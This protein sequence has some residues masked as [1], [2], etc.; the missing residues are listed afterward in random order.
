MGLLMNKFHVLTHLD[1]KWPLALDFD[2]KVKV[3]LFSVQSNFDQLTE[4]F[5]CQ[6]NAIEIFWTLWIGQIFSKL[7]MFCTL[8]PK[9]ITWYK[10]FLW[11][12]FVNQS[13]RFCNGLQLSCFEFCLNPNVSWWKNG[14]KL[15]KIRKFHNLENF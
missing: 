1:E 10:S 8:V 3:W 2:Q 12:N 15:G 4:K 9:I 13:C 6:S 5:I 11:E 14:T 7:K